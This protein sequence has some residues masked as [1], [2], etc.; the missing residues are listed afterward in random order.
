MNTQE[1]LNELVWA[2]TGEIFGKSMFETAAQV[3]ADPQAAQ[4]FLQLAKLEE[5]TLSRLLPLATKYGLSLDEELHVSKG[6]DS[7]AALGAR[8][9]ME[10][11]HKFCDSID[12]YVERMDRLLLLA[13]AE[14]REALEFLLAHERALSAFSYAEVTG[15]HDSLVEIEGLLGAS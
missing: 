1:Y 4:K 3:T 15:R 9:W 7:G 2:I 10:S 6:K 12:E 11:M 13:P 8:D 5:E 14:D